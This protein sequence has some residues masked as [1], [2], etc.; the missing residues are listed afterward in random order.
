MSY[1]VLEARPRRLADGI[2]MA[3]HCIPKQ[4]IG[5]EAQAR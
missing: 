2:S 3:I 5:I 4:E 1:L